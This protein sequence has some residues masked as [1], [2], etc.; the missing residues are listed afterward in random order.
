LPSLLGKQ[1]GIIIQGKPSCQQQSGEDLECYSWRD[2]PT[3]AG[4]PYSA[5]PLTHIPHVGSG[6]SH[7]LLATKLDLLVSVSAE[8]WFVKT[9]IASLV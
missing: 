1:L 9:K 6:Y 5:L 2:R 3:L 7:S 4:H 8:F